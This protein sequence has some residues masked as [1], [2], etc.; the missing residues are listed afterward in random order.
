MLEKLKNKYVYYMLQTKINIFFYL[1]ITSTI[2]I[3]DVHGFALH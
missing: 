3:L 1:K 2:F